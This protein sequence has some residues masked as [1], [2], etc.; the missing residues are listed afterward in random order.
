M[1]DERIWKPL[2]HEVASGALDASLDEVGYRSHCH[3]RNYRFVLGR[4]P[5][6]SGFVD[7]ASL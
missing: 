5:S 3:R 1:I 4:T 7:G 6:R 2:L